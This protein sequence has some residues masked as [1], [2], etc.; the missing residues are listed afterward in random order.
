MF[1]AKLHRIRKIIAS[2]TNLLLD[3]RCRILLTDSDCHHRASIKFAKRSEN[4]VNCDQS[5][6][7]DLGKQFPRRNEKW[8][9]AYPGFR[10]QPIC[11][12]SAQRDIW[13]PIK[14]G[15]QCTKDVVSDPRILLIG[16]PTL[17][18]IVVSPILGNEHF[19]FQGVLRQL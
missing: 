13:T 15:L 2:T 19:P 18:L 7:T 10:T 9:K 16:D 6:I 11:L 12:V 3:K 5:S 17:G 4:V 8:R 14:S 1:P